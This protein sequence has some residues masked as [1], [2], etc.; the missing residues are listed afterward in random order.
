MEVD[1]PIVA[2]I[3]AAGVV[4]AAVVTALVTSSANR[5]AIKVEIGNAQAAER[6][7]IRAFLLGELKEVREETDSLRKRVRT[8]ELE[9]SECI[10]QHLR[11]ELALLRAGISLDHPA[12]T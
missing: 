5:R 1:A 6:S 4:G 9:L 3:T 12:D 10:K 8:T 2:A 7:E 11:A